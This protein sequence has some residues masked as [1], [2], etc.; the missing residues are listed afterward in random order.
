[1]NLKLT[2]PFQPTPATDRVNYFF[3]DELYSKPAVNYRGSDIT[4]S[5]YN[6]IFQSLVSVFHSTEDLRRAE[7][8]IDELIQDMAGL[9]S[10]AVHKAGHEKHGLP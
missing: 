8:I 2:W 10:S 5:R 6:G 9:F 3:E 4:F 1:M 7:K